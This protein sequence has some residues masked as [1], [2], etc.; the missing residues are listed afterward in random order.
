MCSNI[1]SRLWPCLLITV[2]ISQVHAATV[3]EQSAR[4]NS[5]LFIEN[6]IDREY[7]ITPADLDPRFSGSNVWT[8]YPSNQV[9]QGYMGIVGWLRAN[10][11]V[12]MWIDNSPINGP[13]RGIR[14]MTQGSSC[15]TEGYVPA[16]LT[17]QDGFYHARA[18]SSL[19]NGSYGFASFSPA[20]YEYFRTQTPGTTDEFSL[21]YCHTA[22]DYNYAG[23]ERCKDLSDANWYRRSFSATKVGHLRLNSTG[24]MAEVWI[25]SDGTP[26]LN[27]EDGL[28][29]ISVVSG[30]RGL[31]CKM[32]SYSLQQTGNLTNSLRI[33]M[34]I[35]TSYLGITI[36]NDEIKFSGDGNSW[37]NYSS[38]TTRYNEVFSNSGEYIYVFMSNEFFN[39][40]LNAGKSITNQDSVFTFAFRNSNTPES[41]FYQFTASSLLNIIP[42]EY[43]ISIV[44]SDG[45]SK[46]K[47]SGLIGSDSPIEFEYQVTTSASRQ[48][49]SITA[50]VIGDSTVVR[51]IPYCVFTSTDNE[52]AVPVPAYLSYTAKSGAVIR[53]RNSCSEA[54]IDI[55][56]ANWVQTPW[57]AAIDDG[58]FFKT[59]LK[60]IFPMDNSRS[61]FSLDGDDWLGTVSASGEV[62]VTAT[63][64][65][66]ER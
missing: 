30:T 21:N 1:L 58:F 36:R 25:A 8:R 38:S 59:K 61:Q 46:P 39:K 16:S 15:P 19:Y 20:A 44:S 40:L 7:F 32:L 60:L 6:N 48:A 11:Y 2:G 42:K 13:F 51:N 50:Q 17:D 9:S 10:R 41:G 55:T 64:L 31:T 34:I 56:N 4:S 35:D 62:K 52:F 65:G 18:G 49:D 47:R 33:E 57:N 3:N 63:W 66:V 24:A 28:C 37:H 12:D 14:C 26:S 53:Q 43:G 54:P 27:T 5:Y 29:S 23:G 45:I 22:V